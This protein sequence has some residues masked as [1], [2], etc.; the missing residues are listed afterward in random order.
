M[1]LLICKTGI[2]ARK[3]IEVYID[4]VEEAGTVTILSCSA[5]YGKALPVYS[6][7]KEIKE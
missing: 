6:L 7:D 3:I 1:N 5:S 2:Y 4:K